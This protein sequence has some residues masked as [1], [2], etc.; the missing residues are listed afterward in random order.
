MD[1]T[2]Y[3]SLLK[4]QL[5]GTINPEEKKGLDAIQTQHNEEAD[6]YRKVWELAG[7][8]KKEYAPDS[9]KG[10]SQ[11]QRRIAQAKRRQLKVRRQRFGAIAASVAILLAFTWIFTSK[12]SPATDINVTY[13]T[14]IAEKKAVQLPDG[15]NVYLNE[16]SSL[17]FEQEAGPTAVRRVMLHGEAYFDVVPKE[18]PFVI[19]TADV[20]V[21]V[22]GTSFNVRAYDGEDF[23]E[24][25]VE[26]G[27]VAFEAIANEEKMMLEA[28]DRGV[29]KKGGPMVHIPAPNLLAHSWRTKKL[30]FKNTPITDVVDA[31]ERHYKV[32]IDV[33]NSSIRNCPLSVQFEDTPL[34]TVFETFETIFNTEVEQVKPNHYMVR[35]GGCS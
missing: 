16:N 14:T 27:S 19:N 29:C 7:T 31:L 33:S 4:K 10:L 9:Q 24:V 8:Y 2:R 25:E 5:K 17:T 12:E 20:Q 11:L 13:A 23:T 30:N 32:Q 21:T 3:I 22:M 35:G 28:N 34:S 18:E 1:V 6:T 15:S 26:E